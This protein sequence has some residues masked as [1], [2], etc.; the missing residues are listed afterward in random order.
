VEE[1]WIRSRSLL[2]AVIRALSSASCLRLAHSEGSTLGRRLDMVPLS[3]FFLG[4]PSSIRGD[5]D[6]L[7]M[8]GI[9]FILLVIYVF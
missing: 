8:I 5:G 4:P 9:D 3:C 7:W 6:V 2:L 1:L